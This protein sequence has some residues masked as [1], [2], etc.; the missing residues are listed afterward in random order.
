MTRPLAP[1]FRDLDAAE[2]DAVLG[3]NHVGRIAYS[4]HDRVDIEPIHYVYGDG[5]FYLRTEHGSKLAALAHVPWVAFEVD[6]IDGL[7]DWRSVVAHGTVYMLED[8][9][10]PEM[11][12]SYHAAVRRLRELV[13]GALREDD[14]VPDR[15]VV[16]KLHPAEMT[17]RAARP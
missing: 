2:M 17:G 3:R 12:A 6:E 8:A 7:F 4:F 1:T 13:P 14:P 9:G 5:A 16:L 10:S 15:S 11:R